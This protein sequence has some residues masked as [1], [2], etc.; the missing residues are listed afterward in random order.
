MVFVPDVQDECLQLRQRRGGQPSLRTCELSTIQLSERKV[1]DSRPVR[2]ES[3][4]RLF[5]HDRVPEAELDEQPL[6]ALQ[7]QLE[8][9]RVP[10]DRDLLPELGRTADEV[11]PVRADM[12]SGYQIPPRQQPENGAV[13]LSRQL[14]REAQVVKFASNGSESRVDRGGYRAPCVPYLLRRHQTVVTI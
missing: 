3:L 2:A 9:Q 13:Q 10:P 4:Q 8:P 11:A 7:T 12:S 6:G 1:L 5:D 14:V